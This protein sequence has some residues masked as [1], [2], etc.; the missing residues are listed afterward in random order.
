[1]KIYYLS[2]VFGAL[3]Y[4]QG[5][6]AESGSFRYVG[7]C[8]PVRIQASQTMQKALRSI[9]RKAGT[10]LNVYSCYR[11]KG[12][13]ASIRKRNKCS[14]EYGSVD[15]RGRVARVSAHTHNVAAD[16]WGFA[17]I[18]TQCKILASVRSEVG[19]GRGGVGSYPGK[20]GR[21]NGH[22]DLGR[23]RSWNMC[24][25]LGSSGA[26]GRFVSERERVQRF[27]QR[28]RMRSA[29]IDWNEWNRLH[30]HQSGR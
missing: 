12:K 1:M 16:L 2:F 21:G 13:Q 4:C 25:F 22:F 8:N 28:R 26:S 17:P 7:N 29:W 11:D 9:S 14:P 27:K 20:R 30:A 3:I 23:A 15:C 5:A 19:G 6:F 10:Q 24:K 18:T